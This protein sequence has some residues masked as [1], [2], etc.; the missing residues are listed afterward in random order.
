LP[1]HTQFQA[2]AG[3]GSHQTQGEHKANTNRRQVLAIQNKNAKKHPF[4]IP[5]HNGRTRQPQPARHP[6]HRYL[7]QAHLPQIL[8]LTQNPLPNHQ[9][10]EPIRKLT[11]KL[12]G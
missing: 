6:H 4:K 11:K 8:H 9:N 12:I 3:F 1:S 5:S 2:F 7:A 10:N